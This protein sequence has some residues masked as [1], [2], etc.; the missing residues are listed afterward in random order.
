MEN[1]FECYQQDTCMWVCNL[2]H[3]ADICENCVYEDT[4]ECGDCELHHMDGLA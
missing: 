1:K 4:E 3:H 2:C